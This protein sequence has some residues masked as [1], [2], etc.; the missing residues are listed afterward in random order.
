M[1]EISEF[2]FK[3]EARTVVGFIVVIFGLIVIF[4]S[5]FGGFMGIGH[6]TSLIGEITETEGITE[7]QALIEV[8]GW[9]FSL[10]IACLGGFFIASIGTKIIKK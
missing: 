7:T 8:F 1:R 3:I 2:E 9:F 5:V 6:I 4:I 10:L